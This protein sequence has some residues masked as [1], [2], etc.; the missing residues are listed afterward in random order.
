MVSQLPRGR[1]DNRD[2]YVWLYGSD[3]WTGNVNEGKAGSHWEPLSFTENGDIKPLNCYVN[4]YEID[5]KTQQPQVISVKQQA[6]VA[7]KPGN[8]TWSCKLGTRDQNILYQ[9]FRAPKSGNVTGFGVNIAEQANDYELQLYFGE[10]TTE[11]PSELYTP[12]GGVKNLWS[13]TRSVG[14]IGWALPIVTAS[15]YVNVTEVSLFFGL[16]FYLYGFC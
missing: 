15:P 9:F 6:A 8:Y 2:P 3:T 10:A 14:T 12:T 7:S 4:S 13:G 16:K 5:I 1:N 11:Q